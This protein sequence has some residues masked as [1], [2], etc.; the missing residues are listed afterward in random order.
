MNL[1]ELFMNGAARDPK[2]VAIID[3]DIRLRYG[4]LM[5]ASKGL[6]AVLAGA[7]EREAVGVFLPTCV[8]F[9]IAYLA[10]LMAGKIVLPFNFLLCADDLHFVARDAGI[11]TVVTSRKFLKILGCEEAVR[12]C[13]P[14]VIFL[15]DVA[16]TRWKKMR[17]LARGMFFRPKI[18]PEDELATLLYTSGTTGRPKGVELTHR[19]IVENIRGCLEVVSFSPDDVAVQVLPLFHTFALTVTMAV[20]LATGATTVT[21]KRFAPDTLLDAIERHGVTYLVAIPSM[22]R[23]LNRAQEAKP[24]DVSSLTCA[25]SGGEPLPAEVRERF[26]KLFGLE[27][28]E[29]YGR[30]EAAPVVSR[31]P[32]DAVRP[33]SVGKPLPGVEVRAVGEDGKPL[34]PDADGE[35]QVRG[36]NVMRGYHNRPDETAEVIDRDGWLRTGDVAR[37]DADG[38]VSITGRLKEMMIVGGENV[39]PAEIEDCLVQ[40]PAVADVGVVGVPDERRGEAPKAFVVLEEGATATAADILGFARERL[41]AYKV[42]RAV[43]FRDELPKAPTGKVLRRLLVEQGS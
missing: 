18:V 24:R 26:G 34:P 7:T 32:P 4:M 25:V 8:H 1:L 20:P 36:P 38:Y 19:N 13:V 12:G 43:E 2:K 23:V 5:R 30:P 29:G 9:V 14:N 22:F 28:G 21:M 17:M 41:P 31:N 40:H 37:I 27:L 33:G 39:F 10:S 42:P 11:D 15:E 16:G 35:L 6:A 3:D